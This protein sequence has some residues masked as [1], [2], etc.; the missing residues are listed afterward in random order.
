M[1]HG[2][3]RKETYHRE[4]KNKRSPPNFWWVSHLLVNDNHNVAGVL[5]VEFNHMSLKG[6]VAD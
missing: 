2:K 5:E 4:G 6:W 1:Q 3:S